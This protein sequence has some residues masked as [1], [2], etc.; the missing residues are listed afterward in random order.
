MSFLYPNMLWGLFAVLVP[1]L[2]HFLSR[3][4]VRVNFS[5]IF[6]LN[7]LKKTSIK[8]LKKINWLLTLM[9]MAIIFSLI[10]MF[11]SPIV[12]NNSLWIASKKEA[13]AVVFIDNSASMSL[14][15]DGE[16]LLE[17]S[18]KKVSKIVSSYTGTVEA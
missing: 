2:I 4:I 13:L 12:K 17:K 3:N 9:R 10:M 5:S 8:K 16:S 11:A 6:Y 1:I 15:I 14:E 7:E 18:I